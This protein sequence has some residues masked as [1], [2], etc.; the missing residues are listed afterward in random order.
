MS[1]DG[2]AGRFTTGEEFMAAKKILLV[3]DRK[4][5]QEILQEYG[6]QKR[7]EILISENGQDALDTAKEEK[8][9][10]II[11]RKNIPALDALSVSV[12]LKETEDTAKIP[13][14]V[15]CPGAT[16]DEKERFRDA[17]LTGCVEEPVTLEKI[18][19]GLSK[20]L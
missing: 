7:L 6:K 13:V 17:G 5:I 4:D 3:D 14:V 12:L 19:S 15:I 8:P 20:W 10:L 18:K 16:G 11:M 9:D 1:G 2:I